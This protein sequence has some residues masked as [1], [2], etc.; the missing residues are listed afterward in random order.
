MPTTHK[1]NAI[2]KEVPCHMFLGRRSFRQIPLPTEIVLKDNTI[3]VQRYARAY[4]TE[5]YVPFETQDIV[6][7][8]EA[9]D[10][11]KKSENPRGVM[12]IVV[13]VLLLEY[14][15]DYGDDGHVDFIMKGWLFVREP[16]LT[17]TFY[18]QWDNPLHKKLWSIGNGLSEV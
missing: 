3:P 17:S 11:D 14:F 1:L 8:Q 2:V 7:N 9:A 15:E 16:E 6:T 5:F 13:P 10:I 12:S 18:T 4:R